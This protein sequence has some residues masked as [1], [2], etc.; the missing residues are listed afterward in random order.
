[1]VAG[2]CKHPTMNIREERLSFHSITTALREY[3]TRT[4]L[5]AYEWT[6]SMS[7]HFWHTISRFIGANKHNISEHGKDQNIE[8][9]RFLLDEISKNVN[10]RFDMLDSE[11]S[12]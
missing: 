2:H 9:L 11:K 8:Q 5:V 7:D 12:V 10:Q 4:L 1:M 3:P 6:A